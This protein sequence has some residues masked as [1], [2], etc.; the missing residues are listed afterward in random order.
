MAIDQPILFRT[1]DDQK[2][3]LFKLK[4]KY[5]VK[6]SWLLRYLFTEAM[7]NLD[8]KHLRKAIKESPSALEKSKGDAD[9]RSI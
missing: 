6:K 9:A 2:N 1:S 3:K 5:G 8:A 7:N 4:N